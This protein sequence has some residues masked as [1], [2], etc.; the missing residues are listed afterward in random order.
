MSQAQ[1][2]HNIRREESPAQVSGL[3][4]EYR[5]ELGRR[6]RNLRGVIRETIV[7]NDALGIKGG[8]RNQRKIDPRKDFE[9]ERDTL[10]Q[11]E[12]EKQVQEWINQGVLQPLTR[13]EIENGDHYTS[14]YVNA[15]YLE[16]L[17]FA[18]DEMEDY[19]IIV[20]ETD[21]Y[22]ELL[23]R[24]VHIREL[25]TVYTRNYQG[26]ED[27]TE[28]IDRQIGRILSE[29]LKDGWGT[30]RTADRINNEINDIQRTR[31]RALAR[32]EILHTHNTSTLERYKQFDV[33][34]VE[35]LTH[36]PCSECA[37][38][39]AG[40]PYEIG[41]APIPPFH[42]NCVCTIVPA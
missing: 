41:S 1:H 34:E 7:E 5:K 16:G 27:I 10:K 36:N 2:R 8:S 6:I 22:N 13:E 39:E 42:P 11:I 35:I 3:Q 15:A 21:N 19:G 14:V 17:K 9:F 38:I 37:A 26:L 31:A 4:D 12:F 40:D 28:D 20:P 33:A 32:T 25:E 23:S 24:P 18:D 29:S 30:Q